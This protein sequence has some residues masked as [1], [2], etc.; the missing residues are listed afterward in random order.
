MRGLI[1][2]LEGQNIKFKQINWMLLAHHIHPQPPRMKVLLSALIF[3]NIFIIATAIMDNLVTK[4][5]GRLK[6]LNA[7]HLETTSADGVRIMHRGE[8]WQEERFWFYEVPWDEALN[9]PAVNDEIAVSYSRYK[10]GDSMVTRK[11]AREL[12]ERFVEYASIPGVFGPNGITD[13]RKVKIATFYWDFKVPAAH[14]IQEFYNQVNEI[15]FSK[16]L[17][18]TTLVKFT[19]HHQQSLGFDYSTQRDHRVRDNENSK[20]KY[21]WDADLLTGDDHVVIIDDSI[22]TGSHEKTLRRD[23][24]VKSMFPKV[25]KV[26]WGYV[27]KVPESVGSSKAEK[28]LNFAY[29]KSVD[30]ILQIFREDPGAMT[31]LRILKYL[32][33]NAKNVGE[34]IGIMERFAE[35]DSDFVRQFFYGGINGFHAVNEPETKG[36]FLALQEL[37][38]RLDADEE[39]H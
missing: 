13:W 23:L 38:R 25:G 11:F 16:Y 7:E 1:S 5:L 26:T 2:W 18:P 28:E 39:F 31:N 22:I 34:F 35:I 19:R 24:L 32:Y 4:S 10:Y 14:L 20:Q 29:V 9:R 21:S 15:L 30:D 36:H 8:P 33:Q 27:I 17:P 37:V 6:G 3:Y 12:A